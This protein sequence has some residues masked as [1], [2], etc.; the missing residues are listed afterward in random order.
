MSELADLKHKTSGLSPSNVGAID[1]SVQI[2]VPQFCAI[3]ERDDQQSGE[4]TGT[5]QGMSWVQFTSTPGKS[6]TDHWKAEDKVSTLNQ[7][8]LYILFTLDN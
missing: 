3:K 4:R 6:C 1:K 8:F 2:R 7:L 5:T